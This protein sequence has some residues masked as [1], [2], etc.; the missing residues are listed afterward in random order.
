MLS[1]YYLVMTSSVLILLAC[2]VTV[3]IPPQTEAEGPQYLCVIPLCLLGVGYSVYAAALWGCIPYTVPARLI[4]T[5]YGLTTA[6]Q[7]IGLVISP[8]VSSQLLG[9]KKQEG[10]FWLMMYFSSLACIGIFLNCWLYIDDIKN[11][12]G[13]L[14]KVDKGDELE[15]LMTTP[16]A[17]N[18]RKDQEKAL[19]APDDDAE[20]T[21]KTDQEVENQLQVYRKDKEARDSLR[22]SIAKQSMGQH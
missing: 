2:L 13:I 7:N 5:A 21:M 3:M 18:R 22:R 17:E 11:R 8:L 14:N 19:M 9:T 15:E 1:L 10:Y 4:G 12:D 16:V 6:I 20:V